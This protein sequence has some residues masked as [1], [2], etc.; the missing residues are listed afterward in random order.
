MGDLE[1]SSSPIIP[2]LLPAH[3]RR[4]FCGDHS[5]LTFLPRSQQRGQGQKDSLSALD[6]PVEAVY[7][8]L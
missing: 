8:L 1:V 4:Y 5:G 6:I 3:L 7:S 2:A